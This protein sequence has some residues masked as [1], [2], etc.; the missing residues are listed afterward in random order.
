MYFYQLLEQ[1]RSAQVEGILADFVSLY[2]YL[3]NIDRDLV[4]GTI[5]I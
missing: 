5:G 4:D 3:R 1:L 2:I